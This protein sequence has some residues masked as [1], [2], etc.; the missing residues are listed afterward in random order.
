MHFPLQQGT[1]LSCSVHFYGKERDWGIQKEKKSSNVI[2]DDATKIEIPRD[3]PVVV[4]L[5]NAQDE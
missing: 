2:C 3:C 4:K 5:L 1:L